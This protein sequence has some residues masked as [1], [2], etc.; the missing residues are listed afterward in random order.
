MFL[1]QGKQN[2]ME[3]TIGCEVFAG[4][5]VDKVL[6]LHQK[7]P[8]PNFEARHQDNPRGQILLHMQSMLFHMAKGSTISYALGPRDI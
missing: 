5:F 1:Q 3:L 8:G 7:L 6:L 4:Y 2:D